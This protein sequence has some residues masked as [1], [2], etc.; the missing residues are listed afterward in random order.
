VASL[1]M[2][3][4]YSVCVPSAALHFEPDGSVTAMLSEEGEK[5]TFAKYVWPVICCF[6]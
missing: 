1:R 3:C 4:C 5:V 6:N 2:V